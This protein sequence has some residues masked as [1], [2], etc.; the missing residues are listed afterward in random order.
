MPAGLELVQSYLSNVQFALT[1]GQ[2][3]HAQFLV[4]RA[5]EILGTQLSNGTP[6]TPHMQLHI[7]V[8]LNR[9]RKR[10]A[11][12]NADCV[13][14]ASAI[15]SE[16]QTF[17][18]FLVADGVG[19]HILAQKAARLALSVC[20]EHLFPRLKEGGQHGPALQSLLVEAVQRA[21][22]AIFSCNQKEAVDGRGMHATITVMVVV[23]TEAYVANVG[24]CRMYLY[25][26]SSGRLTQITRDHSTVA[27]MVKNKEIPPEA[28]RMHPKRN[29][30]NRGLGAK[31]E[32]E[33]DVFSGP[34]QVGDVY[35]LCSDGLWGMIP[36]E[37]IREILAASAYTQPFTLTE[38]FVSCAL[39]KGGLD[40]IGLVVVQVASVSG[41]EQTIFTPLQALVPSPS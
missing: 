13:F 11:T 38:Q 25:Q 37:E 18:L 5:Q 16:G 23:E 2:T 7:G 6:Q 10:W 29:E 33:I 40:N 3:E 17:G 27:T 22:R 30:V 12:P 8:G 1:D 32:E 19:D 21:N 9:G 31:G 36:D 26:Q 28:M 15:N 41:G 4:D 14:G 35:L 20:V 24:D 39:V 34:V